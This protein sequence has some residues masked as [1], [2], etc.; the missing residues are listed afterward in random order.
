M[1]SKTVKTTVLLL[2]INLVIFAQWSRI[3]V[4]DSVPHFTNHSAIYRSA[5]NS[6]VIY[7]GR[8]VFGMAT[9]QLWNLNLTTNQWTQLTPSGTLPMPRYTHNAHYDALNDRMIVWS[10]Q[11]NSGALHNDVWAYNFSSNS[12]QQRWPDGNTSG[13]PLMRYGTASVFDPINRQF[14]TFAGFTSGGRFEDTWS[15]NV[16]N[17]T[18]QDRTNNPHPPKRCLHAGVLAA[19]MRK[20]VIYA[21]QHDAGPLDDIWTLNIDTYSWQ[22]ITPVFKPPR[23]FWN[24]TIYSGSGSV[25]IFGGLDS[26][27][28]RDMWKFSLNTNQWEHI[29][30]TG[31]I[32]GRRWG[33]SGVYIPVQ[34]RMII[35]GGIGDSGYTDT[36]QYQNVSAIGIQQVS[37][38]IPK[39]FSLEQNYPNPFNPMTNVKFQMPNSGFVKLTVFDVLGREV[40]TLVNEQ[41]Q[42]GV[43]E[44]NWDAGNHPSGVYFYR[45]ETSAYTETK[46][47]LMVK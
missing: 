22:N 38:N 17:M 4:V 25:I 32:P 1:I 3:S 42:A 43:Y 44:V 9:G 30:Q 7:G 46:K 8:N 40:S 28:M 19:D 31:N 24:S 41:L 6:M 15:F 2:C 16:D 29:S 21:G 39:S 12:W 10:G 20:M 45:M 14:V 27:P 33:H 47:M 34:D 13:V 5:V 35:F 26:V 18:W 36:W 37:Q 23:R 11:G